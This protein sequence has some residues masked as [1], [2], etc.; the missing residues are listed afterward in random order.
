VT[1]A[2]TT[3]DSTVVLG[4]GVNDYANAS[5]TDGTAVV[6]G[7]TGV[8]TID[9]TITDSG[10]NTGNI[11]V[12]SGDGDDAIT[13]NFAGANETADVKMGG[14]DDTFTF[15]TSATGASDTI[16]IDG[17]EGT[18]D[19]IDLNG[20]DISAGSITL[21]GIE[22]IDDSAGTGVVDAALLTG[23]SYEIKGD[24]SAATTLDVVIGTAGTFDFGGLTLN[25]S[26]TDGIGG[27]SITTTGADN[28][29]GTSGTDTFI[30]A[31][32]AAAVV[33]NGGRGLDTY[34]LDDSTAG[35][36]GTATVQVA[37]GDSGV[38]TATADVITTFETGVDALKLG[39][40]GSAS[41]YYDL[42]TNSGASDQIAT[43]EL[44]V[45]AANAA[46]GSGTS[47]DGTIQYI[48]VNDSASGVDSYLVAD[49]DLD[50]TADLAIE[51]SAI[52]DGALVA[53]DI[54]A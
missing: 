39:T 25:S 37:A 21:T 41:N 19:S 11:I 44:A 3:G 15:D 23:K 9:I 8:D 43:V 5:L 13:V 29:T 16:A 7:G 10:A 1:M 2:Q 26:L 48:Y 12:Q 20:I 46:T 6:L 24:G 51:I 30:G 35:N 31:D 40:A 17:G 18:G 54:I 53:S 49:M 36:A 42:D 32:V 47:F 4:N 34:T 28:I 38:T 52:A 50:G 22:V 45:A 14:G 27:L 33:L